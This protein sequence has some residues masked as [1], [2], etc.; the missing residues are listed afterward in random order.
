MYLSSNLSCYAIQDLGEGLNLITL[1][2]TQNRLIVF[3]LSTTFSLQFSALKNPSMHPVPRLI[4]PITQ[5]TRKQATPGGADA[6]K[7]INQINTDVA[8]AKD[9]LLLAKVF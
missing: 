8:E 2:G 7:L 1:S 5:A 9:N 6:L 3:I 4:P